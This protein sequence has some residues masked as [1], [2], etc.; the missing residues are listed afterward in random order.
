MNHLGH[1]VCNSQNND[2]YTH[3]TYDLKPIGIADDYLSLLNLAMFYPIG[4]QFNNNITI[5]EPGWLLW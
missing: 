2:I 4:Q 5:L 1:L 3:C